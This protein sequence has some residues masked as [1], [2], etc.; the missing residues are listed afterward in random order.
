MKF[1]KGCVYHKKGIYYIDIY[2]DNKRIRKAVSSNKKEAIAA[3]N[4][5][6]KRAFNEEWG[7]QSE[8]KSLEELC[9]RKGRNTMPETK[10]FKKTSQAVVAI[11]KSKPS[12]VWKIPELRVKL[13]EKAFKEDWLSD[14]FTGTSDLMGK[15]VKVTASKN[16]F[17]LKIIKIH[18]GAFQIDSQFGKAQEERLPVTSAEKQAEID[19][20]NCMKSQVKTMKDSLKKAIEAKSAIEDAIHE[21]YQHIAYFEESALPYHMDRLSKVDRSSS[22]FARIRTCVG[23][24]F[25]FQAYS[26]QDT[27]C[28]TCKKNKNKSKSAAG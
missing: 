15:M 27:Y 13:I 17:G 5:I 12:K 21:L 24:G 1:S 6:K 14:L 23:C 10:K 25:T 2:I 16:D 9:A 19:I 20:I 28:Q 7:F 3:L 4:E 26:G 22:A 8:G 18:K 11:M